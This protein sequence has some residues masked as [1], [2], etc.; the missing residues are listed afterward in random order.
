MA[1]TS[2]APGPRLLRHPDFL[3]L[4]TAETVSVFGTQI[5]LLALPLVAATILNVT[6][7]EFGLLGTIEFLPFILLSLPAG[8]WVDRLRRRP[9][10]VIADLGRAVAL[11]TIPIA[12]YFD[13][14]TI[15]QLYVV[16]FVTGCMTVFFDVAYQSYLPALVDRD[17]LVEGNSKLEITRSASQIAGP[18][19]AGVLIGVLRAPF[20]IL[21]D[22][23]SFVISALFLFWI[24]K[25]EPPIVPHDVATG[26]RPSMRFEI[27]G[28]LRYVTGHR[29][30][31]SIAATTGLS[32]M[33]GN[34]GGAILL[35]Y[36]VREHSFTPEQLGFA[37]SLGSFGV[38]GAALTASRVQKALGLGR[39]LVISALGFSAAGLPIVLSPPSLLFFA[40]AL[41]ILMGG[42]FG[43]V[44]NIN[45]VSLRQAITP[46]RMQ[47]R[48]NATM[49]FIV[50]GTIPVG[51]IA[52]G[53]LGGV[54]GLYETLVVGAA[55]G[56]VAFLPVAMSEVRKLRTMPEQV[57]DE[58]G[59]SSEAPAEA[60]A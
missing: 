23:L 12:F 31:R 24:R 51:T 30:L 44:W 14:L 55:G 17:Q 46:L 49:R 16:G 39:T 18:G 21:V 10:L 48:M 19:L 40:V 54:I 2:P 4:W 7:F 15:W 13:A 27:A 42:Y 26:P 36:L 56:L 57:G 50:W 53:Y 58:D 11:A 9:I 22:A 47:G 3:K 60:G 8:V 43:V 38:L 59:A 37:F 52:G 45:Q 1:A 6:P 29:W 33:F 41:A 28:G 32:N 35:L 34:V 25:P 20:A 5:T